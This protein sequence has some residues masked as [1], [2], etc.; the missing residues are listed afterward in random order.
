M[1]IT[2]DQRERIKALFSAALG[3]STSE[4]AV[5]LVGNCSDPAMR[6]EVERLVSEY[7]QA[8]NFLSG[9]ICE[10]D[11]STASSDPLKRF[12]PGYVLSGRFRILRFIA[13]GGMGE[14]YEAEDLELKEQVA[15][16]TIQTELLQSPQA[17]A[18]FKR[19]VQLSRKVTYPNVCR[20]FDLF[21]HVRSV[22]AAS[23]E[24]IFVSMELLKGRNPRRP[25]S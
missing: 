6:A 9:T 15:I 8:E 25:D 3:L 24:I 18:R 22:T 16:M 1:T 11:Q 23:E 14:V 13:A 5:F 4:R 12:R 2:P 19:E 20:I 7:S 21:R 10:P 17:I